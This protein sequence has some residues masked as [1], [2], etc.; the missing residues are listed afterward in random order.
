MTG[1]DRAT[2]LTTIPYWVTE[3]KESVNVK[4]L[5]AFEKGFEKYDLV[6]ADELGYVSFGLGRDQGYDPWSPTMG[7]PM[8]FTKSFSCSKAISN[9]SNGSIE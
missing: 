3:L 4:T 6:I 8:Q 5:K 7:C 2:A 9:T 1:N